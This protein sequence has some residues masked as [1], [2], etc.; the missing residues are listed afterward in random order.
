[1]HTPQHGVKVSQA[2]ALR[3]YVLLLPT[4]SKGSERRLE[5]VPGFV[6]SQTFLILPS[7]WNAPLLTHLYQLKHS[8]L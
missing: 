6:T 3:P 1:M 4:Y 2:L 8:Q 7:P 5:P